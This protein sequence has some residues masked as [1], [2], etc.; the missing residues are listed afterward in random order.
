M[1]EDSSPALKR[2]K[3][4]KGTQSCWECKRRKI[5][6]TFGTPTDSI[7][8]GCKSRQVKC[9]SQGFYDD[10]VAVVSLA[11]QVEAVTDKLASA[12]GKT[13]PSSTFF[14]DDGFQKKTSGYHDLCRALL[15]VWPPQRELDLITAVPVNIS[16]LFHGVVCVPYSSL[17]G[18][19]MEL[20]LAMLQLPPPGSHPTLI[21]RKLLLLGTFLQGI[22]RGSVKHLGALA[23]TYRKIMSRLVETASRLVTSNDDLVNSLEG[24]ECIMIEAMYHNNAGNLRRAWI[25]HRRAMVIAQTLGL[26]KGELSPSR[27]TKLLLDAETRSRICPEHMWFRLIISDR[28]LSLILGL[29]QG[30]LDSPF[31]SEEALSRCTSMERMERMESIA[32][33][34]ILQR[35]KADLQDLDKTREIDK[36]LQE[37]AE[38]MRPQWWL[39]PEVAPIAGHDGDDN[40]PLGD[41][42]R[43]MN[44]FTHYYL[45]AQLHMPYLLQP[46]EDRKY[47]Y[48]KITALTASR[49]ILSRYISFR[50]SNRVTVYCRGID[51]LAFIASTVLCLA[52]IDACRQ[53][54]RTNAESTV[55]HFLAPQR[56]LTDRG[57]LEKTL[58][59]VQ[60]M[61]E[62][63][64]DAMAC[65]ISYILEHLLAIEAAAT[66]KTSS[67][68][69]GASSYSYYST[70]V[71][72]EKPYE[73]TESQ[74][75][76]KPTD[77]GNH[78]F[79]IHIPYFGT[80]TIEPCDA[81][82]S[83]RVDET[84]T[85]SGYCPSKSSKGPWSSELDSSSPRN[86]NSSSGERK[87]DAR[88][89]SPAGYQIGG[90]SAN[91]DWQTVPSHLD[92]SSSSVRGPRA[93]VF[94]DNGV[95]DFDDF[96]DGIDVTNM[97]LVP[98]LTADVEDWALQ[99]V[100]MALFDNLIRGA[101][102][103]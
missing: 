20:P 84:T 18:K 99:G 100:D 49:E 11:D 58:Q 53:Q 64:E 76:G 9:I 40:N 78:A 94:E 47:D 66:A 80:I 32:G 87:Q 56:R 22:P 96:G 21:A 23:T 43:T 45:L 98:G 101:E 93:E 35:S 12:T 67:D 39:T 81:A 73:E 29:P 88:D 70:S 83:I 86:N 30:S 38:L 85:V 65:N 68:N 95:Y 26:H 34:L 46:S 25:T 61:A 8:D 5:R 15:A 92:S 54:Q 91:A 24:V 3:V 72:F 52:H 77:A 36:L 69:N 37:A 62:D 6:C 74:Y 75:G 103:E 10:A 102:A 4:R 16:G 28:Y 57:I 7:C 19:A 71:S 42:I 27:I 14:S 13:T 50:G 63:D 82:S 33:G 31:G 60:L 55:L 59:C 51:F 97:L 1:L 44:Q 90:Q 79:C 17:L 2:R 41:T 89:K 48:S